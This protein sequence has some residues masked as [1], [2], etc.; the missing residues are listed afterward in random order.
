MEELRTKIMRLL[1]ECNLPAEAV[2]YILK[3]VYRDVEE[4]YYAYLNKKMAETAEQAISA[5]KE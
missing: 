2:Y 3:D 1:N 4:S 5:D